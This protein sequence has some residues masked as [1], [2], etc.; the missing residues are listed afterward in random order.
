MQGITNPVNCH[1][2][3][4]S[5]LQYAND[6]VESRADALVRARASE[7]RTKYHKV[8]AVR[9]FGILMEEAHRLS[10]CMVGRAGTYNKRRRL[11]LAHATFQ[12][13]HEGQGERQLPAKNGHVQPF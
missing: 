2:M 12:Q 5:S 1:I 6:E 4:I 8:I 9:V 11:L 10:L 7:L 13:C 3:Q